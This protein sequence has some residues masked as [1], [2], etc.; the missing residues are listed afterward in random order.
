MRNE[1]PKK[2]LIKKI[3]NKFRLVLLNDETFEEK[4]S[5]RLTPLGVFTVMGLLFIFSI[6]AT[7]LVI[8]FTPL[9]EFI[10]GY[11]DI[12]LKRNL[13]QMVFTVD[14]LEREVKINEKYLQNLKNVLSGNPPV[15]L[16]ETKIDTAKNYKNI[17]YSV[18]A[19]DSALRKY[20]ESEEKF[21]LLFKPANMRKGDISSFLFFTP[22]KGPVT[23]AFNPEQSH[24]GIDIVAPENEAVKATLD[25]TVIFNGW[26]SE[27]GYVLHIQHA[28][29]IVSIYKHNAV[30]LKRTGDYV[31]AGEAIAIVGNSGEYSTGAHLH[32]ELWYNGLPINPEEYMMFN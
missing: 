2:K 25:G 13:V 11:T 8:A 1:Q 14:S 20:V 7:S 30:L 31:K 4:F 5:F 6:I 10:P 28:S 12:N 9:R 27:T 3:R 22:L 17:A 21:N 19:Q 29:N 26:T 16:Q 24:F 23:S 15:G 18:S 32:F